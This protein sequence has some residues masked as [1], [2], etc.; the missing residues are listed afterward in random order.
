MP[1]RLALTGREHGPD[2]AFVLAAIA[3]DETLERLASATSA[4]PPAAVSRGAGPPAAVSRAAA[5]PAAGPPGAIAPADETA[6]P[7][8]ATPAT[9]EGDQR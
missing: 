9:T 7:S 2:L 5:P 1:L 6:P 3:A 4:A 8:G